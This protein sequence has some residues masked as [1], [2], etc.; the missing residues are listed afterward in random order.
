MSLRILV[1]R[2]AE[3]IA[4]KYARLT[5]TARGTLLD[6]WGCDGIFHSDRVSFLAFAGAIG[7]L[8]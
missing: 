8:C 4:R 3:G 1:T 5:Q 7:I 6:F 2:W